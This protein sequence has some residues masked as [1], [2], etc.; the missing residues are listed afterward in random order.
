MPDGKLDAYVPEMAAALVQ[1]VQEAGIDWFVTQG[2][3]GYDGHS[4]HAACF[5]AAIL[6]QRWLQRPG[7]RRREV[8]VLALQ[9]ATWQSPQSA[10]LW[11]P[12]WRQNRRRKLTAMSAHRSQL[13]IRP[14]ARGELP[15]AFE[16]PCD[17]FA[18]DRDFWQDRFQVYQP[19]VLRGEAYR[20]YRP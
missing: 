11:V 7:P 16:L 10:D 15:Q 12:A 4:D 2:P 19:L 3:E 17:R 1:L 5:Q 20:V 9:P 13:A 6:A 18:I 14:L 8:G